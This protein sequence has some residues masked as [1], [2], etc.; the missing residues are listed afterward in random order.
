MAMMMLNLSL[1]KKNE[2]SLNKARKLT[3]RLPMLVAQMISRITV[4]SHPKRTASCSSGVMFSK[5]NQTRMMGITIS[6][7]IISRLAIVVSVA[8]DKIT[9]MT[10]ATTTITKGI[11]M[12][13]LSKIISRITVTLGV[14]IRI[15]AA[16]AGTNSVDMV[17]VKDKVI[18]QIQTITEVNHL[19]LTTSLI[20]VGPLQTQK[21]K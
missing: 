5:H 18:S 12:D 8:K 10:I 6:T 17:M 2:L 1:R 11:T 4:T 20:S 7:M 9:T 3:F 21:T 14:E 13:L 16:T 19:R 15:M